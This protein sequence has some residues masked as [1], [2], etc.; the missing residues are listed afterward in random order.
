MFPIDVMKD[1]MVKKY[2]FLGDQK[3]E[4]LSSGIYPSSLFRLEEKKENPRVFQRIP[5]GQE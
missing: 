3:K 1:V 4:F 2:Y 5:E